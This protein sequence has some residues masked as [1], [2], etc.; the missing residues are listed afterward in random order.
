MEE[1]CIILKQQPSPGLEKPFRMNFGEQDNQRC[2]VE[3]TKDAKGQNTGLIYTVF[4]KADSWQLAL[5]L[6]RSIADM[7][8]S[9]ISFLSE[10]S[11]SRPT[12]SIIYTSGTDIINHRLIQYDRIEPSI[13]CAN[14]VR[15]DLNKIL[16]NAMSQ[17]NWE[18]K[19]RMYSSLQVFSRA[20]GID[21]DPF[22]AFTL[23]WISLELLDR[24]LVE[25]LGVPK[26]DKQKIK[27]LKEFIKR[28]H[29][30]RTDGF[31][32]LV[33]IRNQVMHYPTDFTEIRNRCNATTSY[34]IETYFL[35]VDFIL[36]ST[37]HKDLKGK[38][39]AKIEILGQWE[40]EFKLPIKGPLCSI[41]GQ[42]P[43]LEV[44]DHGISQEKDPKHKDI[45][46]G[47]LEFIRRN[48]V[49]NAIMVGQ[50]KFTLICTG[51]KPTKLSVSTKEPSS[52]NLIKN[53]T[54]ANEVDE[55]MKK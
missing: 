42:H 20:Q 52:P 35:V 15:F 36:G 3:N 16:S 48:I 10:I 2:I 12:P 53:G 45:Y 17:L 27:G 13:P 39:I 33:E 50:P 43:Y 24:I 31:K 4:L 46:H 19:E 21:D 32:E 30:E 44:I 25:R 38:P 5:G 41:P 29:P 47:Q 1:F 34:L 11:V 18:T 54:A 22:I 40:I 14:Y 26:G 28:H 37:F 51:L 6:S 9:I 55:K 7:A 8:C 49:E 23:Y